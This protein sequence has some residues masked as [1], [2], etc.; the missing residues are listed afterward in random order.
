MDS[1]THAAKDDKYLDPHLQVVL[2]PAHSRGVVEVCAPGVGLDLDTLHRHRL[3]IGW[4]G[5]LDDATRR[6]IASLICAP[7]R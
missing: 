4:Q 5:G 6:S 3:A 7:H 1:A 2:R